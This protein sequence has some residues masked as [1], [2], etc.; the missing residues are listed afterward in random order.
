MRRYLSVF[1]L[2]MLCSFRLADAQ[3]AK[4]YG[5]DSGWYWVFA[6]HS[7]AD[8]GVIILGDINYH[9]NVQGD[10][11][12]MK[13]LPSGDIE[14]ART[15]NRL[16]Y[17]TP[18]Y[19]GGYA[20]V[21]ESCLVKLNVNGYIEWTRKLQSLDFSFV[22]QTSD[23]GFISCGSQYRNEENS[24]FFVKFDEF[25]NIEWKKKFAV[26]DRLGAGTIKETVDGGYIACGNTGFT[27]IGTVR[28]W[29][30]KVSSQGRIEWQK[31]L[32]GDLDYA[33]YDLTLTSDGA[34]VLVGGTD[35][36]NLDAANKDAWAMKIDASGEVVWQR[37]YVGAESD[38][39][40]SVAEVRE[41]GYILV[42]LTISDSCW[43]FLVL[44][45]D[46][47]G[48]IAWQRAIGDRQEGI[49]HLNE[50]AN[51]VCQTVDGGYVVVG[52]TNNLGV[53][54]DT[55]YNYIHTNVLAVKLAEEDDFYACKFNRDPHIATSTS[56]FRLEKLT[57]GLKNFGIEAGEIEISVSD[58]HLST[59]D[60]CNW[61]GDPGKNGNKKSK[62]S[63]VRR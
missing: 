14:W 57:F 50:N 21:G 27:K 43:D 39:I 42:G 49:K 51:A 10:S 28:P 33:V 2:V 38:R 29:I 3:W 16:W 59:I 13:L 25:G 31:K 32:D 1:F 9:Q 53:L 11:Y 36:N 62:K 61:E 30:M 56:A 40:R 4:S 20:A 18:T 24:S 58:L 22:Q 60:V 15:Y 44:R 46:T 19:E 8:G 23:N 41:G 12:I 34:Y 26:G 63:R 52:D 35:V 7:T 48:D 17:L 47:D 37:L 55:S 6:A 54:P 5:E 45:M